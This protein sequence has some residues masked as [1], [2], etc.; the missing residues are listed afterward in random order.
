MGHAMVGQEISGSLQVTSQLHDAPQSISGQASAPE[1]S[2]V[3]ALLPQ[4]ML[5]HD[6]EPEHPTSQ[7][8]ACA[9]STVPHA[10]VL[11]HR[12]VQS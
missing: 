7:L 8:C 9:Q 5:P 2:I 12:I 3:H 6:T 11:V 4:L 10:P 1:Q